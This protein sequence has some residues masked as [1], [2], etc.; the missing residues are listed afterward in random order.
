MKTWQDSRL[1]AFIVTLGLAVIGALAIGQIYDSIDQ[2]LLLF[3]AS[4]AVILI[5]SL[6]AGWF[7]SR[8]A[9]PRL[10]PKEVAV[11]H[12]PVRETG[13]V[14]WFNV[15][16]GF[17]FIIRDNG[18]DLFVHFRAINDGGASRLNEGQR[19]EYQIGQG[20]KGPQAEEVVILD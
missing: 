7:A 11:E 16:K 18:E 17:G 14:K 19:V 4:A 1:T 8:S 3:F 15:D 12:E 20:R 6:L 9:K 13:K 2:R 5:I 10:R